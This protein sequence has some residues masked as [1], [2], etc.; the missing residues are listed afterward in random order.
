MVRLRLDLA[1]DGTDFSGWARQPGRRT[2]QGEIEEA[3]ARVL[4]LGEAPALTVAGRTDAGVH[5]R[6]QVAH[7]DVDEEALAAVEGRARSRGQGRAEG[8]GQ[9]GA[10]EV[11]GARERVEER[12]SAL[13]RRLAGVLPPDVRVHRVTVAPEGF[14][15][16]FS[17]LSRRYAYRVC[18]APGGVDPLR[19]R[20]V[21]W[22][23]RP[24]DLDRLNTAAARLLGEH[25]FA[26]FCK[27]R[28]GATTIREL[29][30]LDWAREGGEGGEGGVLVATVVADAFCHSMVRALVGSLLAVGEGRLGV[31]WPGQVLARAVRDSGVHVAPAHGLCLE[32]VRYPGAEELALRAALTRRVRVPRAEADGLR[33]GG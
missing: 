29:Q 4:R 1:Y 21:V 11:R 7:L 25:D 12:L 20:E 26:A 15:A 22:Y 18:D 6:G 30:R 31:E 27:K 5:A 19:R 13:R 14:D 33:A 28:E 24:L 3:L 9:A 10:A 23:A 32:E 17:A 8:V 2:V 16:R